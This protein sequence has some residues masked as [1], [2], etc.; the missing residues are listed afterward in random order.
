MKMMNRA[1][2]SMLRGSINYR[3]KTQ[4]GTM[5]A[6]EAAELPEACLTL[7]SNGYTGN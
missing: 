5:R 7:E 3:I 6:K 2:I 4:L 1:L